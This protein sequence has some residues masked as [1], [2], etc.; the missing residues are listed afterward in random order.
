MPQVRCYNV[1]D[2][3]RKLIYN[4]PWLL[5]IIRGTGEQERRLRSQRVAQIDTFTRTDLVIYENPLLK[6]LKIG[7][8][9]LNR[10]L[11]TVRAIIVSSF[12]RERSGG[13]LRSTAKFQQPSLDPDL[14]E[15]DD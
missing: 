8:H 12:R 5:W 1:R 15:I 7:E 3:F 6:A 2:Q 13:R 10:C 14:L 4:F 11:Q 9:A